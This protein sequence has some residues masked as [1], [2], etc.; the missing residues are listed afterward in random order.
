MNPHQPG[1][2]PINTLQNPKNNR[3]CMEVTTRGGKQTMNPPMFSGV[4]AENRGMMR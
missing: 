2:L 3:L 1:T 4:E